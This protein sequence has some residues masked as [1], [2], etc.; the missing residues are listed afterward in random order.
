MK[1]LSFA[2]DIITLG[3]FKANAAHW[4][5]KLHKSHAPILITQHGKPAVV[6]MTPHDF[7]Q[8]LA[9]QRVLDSISK[10][11]ANAEADQTY[12]VEEI[13]KLLTQEH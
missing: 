8:I 6:V 13:R 4:L 7:D 10:R 3:N 9:Q 1:P 12:K 11:L 5:K 2:D